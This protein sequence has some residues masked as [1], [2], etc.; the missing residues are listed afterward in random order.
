MSKS[1]HSR[2]LDEKVALDNSEAVQSL[3]STERQDGEQGQLEKCI[4][5]Q[6]DTLNP[7]QQEILKVAAIIGTLFRSSVLKKASI[8]THPPT[9]TNPSPCFSLPNPFSSSE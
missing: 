5:V 3:L 7:Q 1:L 8:S 6:F 9:Y 4:V 2:I